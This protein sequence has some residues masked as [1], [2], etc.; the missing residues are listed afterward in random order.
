[1]RGSVTGH[2]LEIIKGVRETDSEHRFRT[3]SISVYYVT[4]D[5]L[6]LTVTRFVVFPFIN[7][8]SHYRLL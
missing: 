5:E 8:L 6:Y 7:K 2:V 1:M 4:Y 3:Y